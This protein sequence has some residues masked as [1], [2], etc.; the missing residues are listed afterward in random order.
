MLSQNADVVVF[1]GAGAS[2]PLGF[3]TTYDF[4]TNDPNGTYNQI[5]PAFPTETADVE[6]VL[7]LLNEIENFK[8]SP[9]GMLLEILTKQQNHAKNAYTEHEQL[10]AKIEARCRNVYSQAPT[11]LQVEQLFKPLFEAVS[12]KDRTIEFY[13]TNYDPV[14]D[15]IMELV[16]KMQLSKT[17]GFDE[18]TLWEPELFDKDFH[19]RLFR[20]HGSMSYHRGKDGR[21][22]N[23]RT[24][25][26]FQDPTSQMLL[27]PGFKGDPDAL[28]PIYKIP[29]EHFAKSIKNCRI[30]IFIGFSFRDPAIN[31]S[32]AA[33]CRSNKG[34]SLYV[35]NPEPEAALRQ[36]L[37]REVGPIKYIQQKFDASTV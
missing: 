29:N 17:D 11:L 27:Y 5:A 33:A 22:R 24:Y 16:K 31:K 20:M 30:A 32:I 9:A 14:T 15:V 18:L 23:T 3:P 1:T 2:K 4:W 28:D 7:H 10:I 37:P 8:K 6:T 25:D 21:V 12:A 35:W 36:N 26:T 13:T 19:F 34:L